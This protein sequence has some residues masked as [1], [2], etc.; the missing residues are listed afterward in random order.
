MGL[1]LQV[2]QGGEK[3]N[4]TP[5][6]DNP[7]PLFVYGSLRERQPLHEWYLSGHTMALAYTHSDTAHYELRVT[8]TNAPFPYMV[9]SDLPYNSYVY[10]EVTYITDPQVLAR[11]RHLEESAGYET[12]QI[13]INTTDSLP[14]GGR[15][16]F[17][18]TLETFEALAFVHPD[19][20]I[21]AYRIQGGDWLR[22]VKGWSDLAPQ[23]AGTPPAQE[24]V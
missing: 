18:R 17:A 23:H 14:Y 3:V 10:G 8:H 12:R 1:F 4:I 13:Y 19:P 9:E 21:G 22:Y 2:S 15:Y 5:S 7:V 20:D 16:S 24:M 11:I 6:K